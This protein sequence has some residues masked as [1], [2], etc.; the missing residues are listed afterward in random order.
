MTKRKAEMHRSRG[1][2]FEVIMVTNS[3]TQENTQLV[4]ASMA[5]TTKHMYTHTHLGEGAQ[6]NNG[7]FQTFK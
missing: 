4:P 6:G 2:H 7:L 3:E 5:Q 1:A